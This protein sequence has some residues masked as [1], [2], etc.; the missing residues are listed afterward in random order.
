MTLINTYTHPFYGLW[1]LSGITRVSRYQNQSGFYWSKRQWVAVAA[2]GP[3][4]NLHLAPDTYHASS[5]L[6]L[7]LFTGW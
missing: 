1:T 7:T 5:T 4:A 6:P 2:A 3:Y